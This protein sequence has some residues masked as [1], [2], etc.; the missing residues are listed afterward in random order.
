[1][2][3]IINHRTLWEFELPKFKLMFNSCLSASSE[4]KGTNP[5]LSSIYPV[6]PI[7]LA[8]LWA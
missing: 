4:K 6:I 1:M 2:I 5:G 3:A 7:E 8:T